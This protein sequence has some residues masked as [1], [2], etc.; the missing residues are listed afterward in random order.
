MSDESHKQNLSTVDPIVRA[1]MVF[2]GVKKDSKFGRMILSGAVQQ[3]T[4]MMIAAL[5][6]LRD[7]LIERGEAR[8]LT[9]AS[10]ITVLI[11]EHEAEK[12]DART[13]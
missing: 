4:W 11:A 10:Q 13:N 8:H 2:H 9:A 1:V 7:C 3:S 6:E 5:E 12:P